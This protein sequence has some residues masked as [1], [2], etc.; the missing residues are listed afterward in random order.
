[1]AGLEYVVRP[2]QTERVSLPGGGGNRR[3]VDSEAVV[4]HFVD[5]GNAKTFSFSISQS[6]SGGDKFKEVSRKTKRVRIENPEDPEQFVVVDRVK[7]I[8][9]GNEDNPKQK[10]TWTLKEPV[11]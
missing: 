7:K 4:C 2:F 8:T 10:L 6:V 3:Q 5:D 1:M 9:V 11:T